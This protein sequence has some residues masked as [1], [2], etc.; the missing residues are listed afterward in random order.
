[1]K[2][3]LSVVLLLMLSVALYAQDN[4][5]KFLGIPVDGTRASI[6]RKI[7]KKGFVYNEDFS[8]LQGEFNGEKV[9]VSIGTNKNK[10]WRIIVSDRATRDARQIKIRYNNLCRQFA[11]NPRYMP[12]SI[13][14]LPKIEEMEYEITVHK[15]QYGTLYYQLP[16]DSN[17]RN[18]FV[19]FAIFPEKYGGYSITMYY[20]NTLNMA[21]GEDL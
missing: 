17:I 16:F 10:V 18:R 20:E 14:T 2:K 19:W 13:D 8:R 7:E 4:V 5:T 21:N 11:E 1:M 15:K 12:V 6:I 3:I 9:S